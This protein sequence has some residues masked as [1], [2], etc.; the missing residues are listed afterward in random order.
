MK[1]DKDHPV[2]R[3]RRDACGPDGHSRMDVV[4]L[5]ELLLNTGQSQGVSN[6]CIMAQETSSQRLIRTET[7]QR[8][9]MYYY[10]VSLSHAVPA[11][12]S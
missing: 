10:F 8:I 3:D 7:K 9:Y 12:P 4:M 6:A 2:N 11:S 5:Y 1:D